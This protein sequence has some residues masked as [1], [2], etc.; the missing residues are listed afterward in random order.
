MDRENPLC[1]IRLQAVPSARELKAGGVSD[2]LGESTIGLTPS[3]LKRYPRRGVFLVSSECAMYC[4]FCNRKRAV[5]KGHVWEESSEET[6]RYLEKDKEISEVIL[7]GGDPLML[8][9]ARFTQILERLRSIKMIEIIRVSTRLPVVFPEGIRA[10]H[11]KALRKHAPIWLIIHINH[12]NEV[13][14]EFVEVAGILRRAG[15]VLISQTVLLS[16]I[17]DCPYIL[18]ALFQRLVRLGIKPYYLFQLDDVA[19][20]Q[21]FK[22]GVKSG[23][24]FVRSLRRDISGLCMPVYAVDITGGVG[25]VPLAR[26]YIVKHRGTDLILRNTAGKKGSYKDDGRQSRCNNCGFCFALT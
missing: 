14:K 1:P 3:F 25:K 15:A 4:R 12:P 18:S 8:A 16:R 11:V 22:V 20:A 26:D 7:S 2:P 19:G 9:P 23:T 10:E 13:T 21:H 17:N 6:F 24:A 5:G